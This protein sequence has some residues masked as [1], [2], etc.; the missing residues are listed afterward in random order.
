MT[1]NNIYIA[2]SLDGFIADKN[3]G[4]EFLDTFPFEES[5]D[6]GY[7]DFMDRMDALLMGRKTFE[8]VLSFGIDWPYTKP[9]YVWTNT[10]KLPPKE[11]QDKVQF[12]RGDLSEILQFIHQN[13]HTH[14]YIDGGKTIQSFLREHLIDEMVITTIPVLIGEGIP[15]FGPVK[16]KILF[17]CIEVKKYSNGISQKFYKKI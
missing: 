11:L 15:L 1:S 16:E 2:T 8:K 9:V 6:V 13:N 10:L 5:D 7:K 4:I 17:S 12:V 3:G 14:L